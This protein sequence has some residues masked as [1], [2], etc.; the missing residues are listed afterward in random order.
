[1]KLILRF[2]FCAIFCSITFV[3]LS[4]EENEKVGVLATVNGEPVTVLD[5][6]ELC[7]WEESRL[8]YMYRGEKLEKEIEKLRIKTLERVIERKLVF[9]DFV[10]RKFTLPKNFEESNIDRLIKSSKVNNREEFEKLLISQGTNMADFRKK[11]YENVAVDALINDRCYRDTFVTPREIYDF[12]LNNMDKF[13]YS[14]KVRLQVLKLNINGIH[15][16]ELDKLSS[17]LIALF[18]DNDEKEFYDSVLLYSEGPNIDN[19]GDIGWIDN[20]KLRKDFFT[21]T[22]GKPVGSIVGPVKAPEGYY[23]LRISGLK[24]EVRD[25]FKSVKNKIKKDMLLELKANNYKIFMDDLRG[26][27]YIEYFIK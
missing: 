16:N 4:A 6:L 5:I 17:H 10:E 11:A 2:Y 22:E 14:S 3:T 13:T 9:Q 1:M 19:E 20:S 8:P 26:D 7:G 27:A 25:S 23:F 18:K 21:V 24:P 15:K 12:Y